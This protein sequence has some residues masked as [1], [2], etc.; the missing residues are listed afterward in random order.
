[1][2]EGGFRTDNDSLGPVAVPAAALY[3]PQTQRAVENFPVSGL[4]L[5]RRL[6]RALALIKKAAAE[7][8]Q[9]TGVLPAAV[10][11]PIV[12]AAV[13]VADGRHDDQFPL[14]I[15]QTGSGTSNNKNAHEGI[16]NRAITLVGGV[17]GSKK[18]I[19]HTDHVNRGQSSNDVVP[20]A[21]HVAAAEAL[22]RDLLP[23]LRHLQ[24]ALEAKA[25]ELDPVVKIG[26]T[27][28]M[29]AVPIRLGQELS[30]HAAQLRATVARVERT[31][32]ALCEL[33]LGGT[34]VGTGL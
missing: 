17:V 33:A 23:A 12:Q 28:L 32:P 24:G 25:R 3:G 16:A 31:R 27:H 1:M 30:G 15:F 4:R 2:S 34:A 20:T 5:P 18:P 6:V 14:D 9:Q 11:D 21:V 8:N 7:V 22:E 13:E 29:D 10:T 26:R 19:H